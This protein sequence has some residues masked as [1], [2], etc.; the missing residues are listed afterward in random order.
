[1]SELKPC[2][3]CGGTNIQHRHQGGGLDHTI[4]CRDCGCKTGHHESKED[5]VAS[6]NRRAPDPEKQELVEAL[7]KVAYPG[8]FFNDD[9]RDARALLRREEKP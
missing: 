4:R 7:R 8:P 5:N 2:P 9:V 6:W 1:M 3:F